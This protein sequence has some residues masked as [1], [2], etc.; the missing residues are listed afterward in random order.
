[1]TRF[2][3]E[4]PQINSG[5][6]ADIAFLLLTFFLITSSFDSKT[7]IYRKMNPPVVEN[8]LKKRM[9][10]Q[11]RNLLTLTIDANDRIAFENEEFPLQDIRALSKTFI[12]NPDNSD[13]L[14]EKEPLD[15][16]EIGSFAVTSKHVISLHV[17]P[18]TTY[19]TYLSV[20]SEI[21][22]AYNEL[23]NETANRL[24]Q[25]PFARLTPEQK[26]AIRTAFPYH[27]SETETLNE[28]GAQ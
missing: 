27:I 5:A 10:I 13:F 11:Q 20:L 22:A 6:S 24:F 8:V 19:Q 9:D 28:G 26:E 15:I 2:K 21:T 12:S 23:R 17:D 1:M 7:G 4:I 18:E 14:P 16:P 3:R 25:R